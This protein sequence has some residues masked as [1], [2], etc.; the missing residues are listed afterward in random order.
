MIAAVVTT[1]G[2]G[3]SPTGRSYPVSLFT[4]PPVMADRTLVCPLCQSHH[5]TVFLEM[6]NLLVCS[7]VVC[8]A[9]F[10][11]TADPAR[12]ARPASGASRIP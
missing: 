12:P 3:R 9:S 7:C 2:L 11:V 1:K 10:T 6:P 8:H 5:V 4:V